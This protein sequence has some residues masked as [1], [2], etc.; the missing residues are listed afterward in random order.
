MSPGA[1]RW[2]RARAPTLYWR[3]RNAAALARLYLH[4]FSGGTADP[5]DDDFW[6]F[7]AVGDW[8]GFARA[9]LAY[10]PAQSVVDVGCGHGLA[11]AGF[12]QVDAS[13][14]LRGFDDSDTAR[15]RV[16]DSGLEVAPLDI[17]AISESAAAALARELSAVDLGVCLEVAEHLPPWHAEKLL[18]I[19]SAPRRLVFSAAQPNQGGQFHVN[20]QPPEYWIERLARH[21]L[22]L[23]AHDADFRRDVAALDLPWWYAANVHL[24][25]RR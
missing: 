6:D 18:T 21:G 16:H 20:E 4:R 25:E 24:F 17:V 12:R 10:A 15:R 2:L 3:G 1:L 5:Y 22:I 14:V 9:V 13:I 23:S 7:H 11:L 19:L 8:A